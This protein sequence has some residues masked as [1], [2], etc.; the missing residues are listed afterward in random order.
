MEEV[1]ADITALNQEMIDL[2]FDS[3]S[4]SDAHF[5][6]QHLTEIAHVESLP[7]TIDIAIGK[8][9]V[10]H[11]ACE[12]TSDDND[13]WVRRKNNITLFFGKSSYY[14]SRMLIERGED[15]VKDYQLNEEDYAPFGG[16][17]PIMS[18][19]NEVLG[20]ITV[21]GLLDHLD[22]ELVVRALKWFHNR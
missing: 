16:S 20:T 19:N 3:F 4:I 1:K 17:F 7:I 12:G 14:V 10:Y 5:I 18:G 22:H 8:H 11:F 6:G 2:A 9:Q 15:I 21:S 13:N